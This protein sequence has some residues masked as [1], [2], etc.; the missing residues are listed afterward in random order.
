MLLKLRSRLRG[1]G[2]TSAF[3]DGQRGKSQQMEKKKKADILD[4]YAFPNDE[5]TPVNNGFSNSR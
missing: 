3:V 2:T 4:R 5:L 1:M